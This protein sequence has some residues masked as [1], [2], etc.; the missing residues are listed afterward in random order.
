MLWVGSFR[1]DV[2]SSPCT[3]IVRVMGEAKRRREAVLNGPCPCGSTKVARR[4]CFNGRDWHKPPAVLGL[5]A[6][7]P[8][9]KVEKCYMKELGSCVGPISGEHIISKSVILVLRADGDFS[10]SGLPWLEAA[11]KRFSRLTISKRTV[12]VSNI[13][14]RLLVSMTRLNI[15]S[16]RSNYTLRQ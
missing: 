7:P 13:T 6:F 4:C 14:A 10:I 16:R 15:S 1:R 9:S 11:K 8:A 3:Y 12:F 5:K 2:I